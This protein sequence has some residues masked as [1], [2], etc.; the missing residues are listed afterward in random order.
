[1]PQPKDLGDFEIGP[2]G[3]VYDGPPGGLEAL[4]SSRAI[5][6]DPVTVEHGDE[7]KTVKFRELSNDQKNAVRAFAVQFIEDRRR[8]QEE[9]GKGEWRDAESDRDVLVAEEMELRMLQASMLDPKTNGPACSLAWLRKRMGTQLQQKLGERYDAFEKLIDPEQI[10]EDIIKMVIEDVK[11][12]T[13][14]DLLCM[15]YG[16][17]LLAR[18][19]QYLG[20][21][22]FSSVTDKSNGLESPE[23]QPL[24]KPKSKASMLARKQPRRRS[25]K[26]KQK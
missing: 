11:K 25:S 6:S 10:D 15:Q 14:L 24:K 17:I 20:A 23:T 5:V 4:L 26:T 12:N 19:L 22:H 13:P 21:L 1:M 8:T 9:D 16:S 3:V 7:S 2:N 18:S